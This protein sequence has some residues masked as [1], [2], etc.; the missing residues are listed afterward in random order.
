V[1]VRHLSTD[2]EILMVSRSA[3][4][5][6]FPA[7]D[8][9]AT[10]RAT[11]G[12]RGMALRDGDEVIACDI[13]RNDTELLVVTDNG[14]GKRTPVASYRRTKR[15]AF[16]VKTIKLT[17]ARGKLAGALVVRPG[18]QIMLMSN[19]GT[20]IRTPVDQIRSAGRL[21]QG[22]SVMKPREG[23]FVTALAR[24]AESDEQPEPA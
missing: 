23:E 16:G 11:E 14:F 3:M 20:V 13:A 22:V 6:R 1:G 7:S 24:V 5:V 19:A 9:R 21:T 4:A 8:V 2:D 17:Q 10:G 18:H 12:V 15:G